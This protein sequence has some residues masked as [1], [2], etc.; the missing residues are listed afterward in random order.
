MGLLWGCLV[1]PGLRQYLEP[2]LTVRMGV[3]AVGFRWGAASD[4]AHVLQ[5]VCM[6]PGPRLPHRVLGCH[7]HYPTI[8]L[9]PVTLVRL[10]VVFIRAGIL[11]EYM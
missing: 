9:G 4:G 6:P 7:L 2:Y 11:L 5:A 3:R 1:P 10:M 8:F